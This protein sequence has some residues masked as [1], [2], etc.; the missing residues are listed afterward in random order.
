MNVSRL[1]DRGREAAR[2][3]QNPS[4]LINPGAYLGVF[5][6]VLARAGRDKAV[7][8]LSPAIKQFGAWIEQLLAE[9]TGK[10]GRGILPLVRE[11]GS[12]AKSSGD[13]R[14]HIHIGL[15]GDKA[16]EISLNFLEKNRLPAFSFRLENTYELG[17]QFFIWEMATAI[18][19]HYLRVNPFDQPDVAASKEKTETA[20]EIYKERKKL[21]LEKPNQEKELAGFLKAAAAGGYIAVQAFLPPKPEIA[22][23]LRDFIIHL[24]LKTGLPATFDFG[25]RFLHSTG[26]LHKGGGRKGL[27][28]QLTARHE[29]DADVPDAPGAASSSY[30]FGVLE[31]AQARGDREALRKKGR[32]VI[33]FHFRVEPQ[34]GIR[35]LFNKVR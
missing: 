28:I 17:G 29:Q 34:K 7:F 5:L 35:R 25:P 3:C 11:T 22:A 8:F 16:H 33:H 10:E 12:G 19:G 26:Q 2:L 4:V 18:A 13:D 14:L 20:L 15:K 23:A 24:R 6:G 1:L 9:S 32:P 30:S 21:P 27:F 31:D